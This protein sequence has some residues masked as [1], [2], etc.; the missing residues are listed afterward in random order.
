MGG[1]GVQK[2][3]VFLSVLL[4]DTVGKPFLMGLLLGGKKGDGGSRWVGEKVL[5]L[6]ESTLD[7][8]REEG[9]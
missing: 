2:S 7:G 6:E 4:G 8:R 3:E 9:R 1:W 5:V